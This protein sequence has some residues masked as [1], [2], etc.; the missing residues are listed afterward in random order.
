MFKN[1]DSKSSKSPSP[2]SNPPIEVILSSD[3][4]PDSNSRLRQVYNLILRA[5]GRNKKR[6]PV[7]NSTAT[8]D[9]KQHPKQEI[10]DR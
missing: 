1:P 9:R 7:Q 2:R 5:A 6:Y 4:P 10:D 8:K 3:H